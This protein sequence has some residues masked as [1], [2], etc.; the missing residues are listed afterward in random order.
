M[1][2]LA[3]FGSTARNDRNIDSDIDLIG[4]Y[5][6]NI[7]KAKNCSNTS[8]FLYPEV[9][10]SEKMLSGDLFA[11]HL[12]KES[13]PLYGE[14]LLHKV[15]SNFKYKN[16]YGEEI[17]TS[18]KLASEILKQYTQLNEYSEANKKIVWCLRTLIIS[19]SAQD[20]APVFSKQSI[21]EYIPLSISSKSI[22]KLINLKDTK[23]QFSENILKKF[24][25]LFDELSKKFKCSESST[26][27]RLINEVVK[28]IQSR[29]K[30]LEY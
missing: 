27:E 30:L 12:V 9:L 11:L 4:I 22:L 15:Y 29:N 2:A 24:N 5:D 10:L 1:K 6:E 7:I 20:R 19:L 28:H 17:N 23:E 14:E 13:V 18:L 21:S 26:N 3:I 16:S 25:C 8:L